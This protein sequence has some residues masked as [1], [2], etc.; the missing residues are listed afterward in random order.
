VTI[1]P[2][3]RK[4]DHLTERPLFADE[5]KFASSQIAFFH[6]LMVG[7]FF[8]LASGY[9][10]IQVMESEYYQDLAHNNT[11]RS[12]PL[13][14]PRGR[15][16]DRDGRVI[17]DNL[18]S[19]SCLLSRE[20]LKE[21]HLPLIAEGL[22][23]D[24]TELQERLNRFR[25]QARYVPVIIKENLTPA[26]VAFVDANRHQEM[27]PEI[28]LIHSVRRVYPKEQFLAHVLGYVGEA[29]EAELD[30]PEYAAFKPGDTIGK[31]GLERVYNDTL[32]GEDG[33]RVSLVNNRGKEL[34]VMEAK[35][36]EPGKALTLTIDLDLQ[37]VAE[38]TL[39]GK[40]GAVVALD[41]RTGEV[42]AMASR[43]AFDPNKFSTRISS[44][45]WKAILEDP[46]TPMFNRAL[47]SRLAPG[48][49]IKPLVALAAL[50]EGVIG[51]DHSVNC[52][53]HFFYVDHNF[54]CH[55][56][57]G[58]HGR[59]GLKY[60]LAQ[61]CDVY[62]Y[63]VG[64]QLGIDRLAKWGEMAGLGRRTGIDLP[65]ESTGDL[66]SRGWKMQRLK[67]GWLHGDMINVSIGQGYLTTTPLQLAHAIGGI[68]TGGVWNPPHLTKGEPPREKPRVAKVNID[69]I[70]QVINGMYA[71]VNQGGTASEAWLPGVE[72][73]GKT[74][75]SQLISNETL[76]RRNLAGIVKDNA[77]FVGFAPRS[78]PEIVVAALYEAGEHG[79]RASI[80]AR[81]VIKAY[82][83][84]KAR[85]R[86]AAPPSAPAAAP[87]AVAALTTPKAAR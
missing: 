59:V 39:Q 7:V 41:P 86:M 58:G 53:G 8:F 23:L 65:G 43:P 83:D 82:F 10:N 21:E 25:K 73:C 47:Q 61:S 27:F 51:A 69:N 15:I 26:D 28:E 56:R 87:P 40:R 9:W 42:L 29:S 57:K 32:M 84:K 63:N 36:A 75:T 24:L 35:D 2:S 60:A 33:Q 22:N 85:Q 48:S 3:P 76:K 79:D 31:D 6:Y 45:D 44:A 52:P 4:P 1:F 72:V 19:Y 30:R 68:A 81:D 5:Q 50:E 13:P 71:V 62:F 17:V 12:L 77:W 49:A 64:L 54:L 18:S 46:E 80:L 70:T 16:L 20:R 55:A 37:A 34:Q 66:P 14:A 67:Q 11:V 78:N 74:G 38:L